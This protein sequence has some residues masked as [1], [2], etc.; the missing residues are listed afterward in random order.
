MRGVKPL[1][2]DERVMRTRRPSATARQ[3]R[4]ADQATLE[5]SLSDTSRDLGA[6]DFAFRRPGV[7][8]RVFRELRRGRL[9]IDDEIDLHGMTR[10]EAKSALKGF[11][12]ESAERGLGCV[13]V[14][15]GKG[16]R[17]GP[18]GPVLKTRV[19]DWLAQWNEVLA[20]ASAQQKHG[21]GGAVYVLLRRR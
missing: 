20:F 13:R 17:S 12:A 15:H 10:A 21:G 5:E 4:A 11:I 6:D 7:S 16:K 3:R 1:Q 19:H 14:V 8:E 18:E 9:R 2:R